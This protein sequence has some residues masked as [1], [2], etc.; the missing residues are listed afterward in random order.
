MTGR[1]GVTGRGATI[2]R[3]PRVAPIA[4]VVPAAS[5]GREVRTGTGVTIGR[6]AMAGVPTDPNGAAATT[7][8]PPSGTAAEAAIRT[9]LADHSA[10]VPT[11]KVMSER[12]GIAVRVPEIV[13]VPEIART[14]AMTAMVDRGRTAKIPTEVPVVQPVP[15]AVGGP[16]VPGEATS[17][18]RT[19]APTQVRT[20]VVPSGMTGGRITP[21]P[22]R[23]PTPGPWKKQ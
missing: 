13:H 1:P 3:A 15:V 14:A 12:A 23:T 11:G 6:G 21:S 18:V 4:T 20:I 8:V 9:V 16:T 19:A 22:R 5:T 17:A 7:A 2:G 10:L